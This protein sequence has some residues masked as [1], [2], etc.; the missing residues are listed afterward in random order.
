MA[1]RAA[2][3]RSE[4]LLREE[5]LLAQ[6]AA[7]TVLEEGLYSPL[8]LIDFYRTAP[9]LQ[10]RGRFDA[11]PATAGALLQSL[12]SNERLRAALELDEETLAELGEKVPEAIPAIRA[13]VASGRLE[14]VYGSRGLLS[15]PDAES[16]L[17]LLGHALPLLRQTL[18][19]DI[20]SCLSPAGDLFPQS[21][22]VL[23]GF[24]FR[25]LIAFTTDTLPS[26]RPS[27]TRL[28]GPDGSEMAAAFA[29]AGTS[30]RSET[31]PLFWRNERLEDSRLATEESS[32]AL[33][34]RLNDLASWEGPAAAR[35]AVAARDDIRF[36]TP[37][38][39]FAAATSDTPH[40]TPG[41]VQEGSVSEIYCRDG[42]RGVQA[43]KTL[44]LAECLDALAFAMG[45]ESDERELEHAW[46]DLLHWQ[47]S[48]DRDSV[49]NALESGR[50]SAEAAAKFLASHVD[51]SRI[52]GRGL[53]VFNPSSWTRREY[54]EVT[55]GGEGY[56]IIQGSRELASQ[57][58]ERR[59]GYVTLGF[60]VQVPPLGYRLL[61]V[62]SSTPY[63]VPA[64]VRTA[65][66]TRF[67]ANQFYSAEVG[68]RGGVSVEAA[69]NVLVDAAG[70][71]SAWKD[72]RFHDSREGVQLIEPDRWGPV[73]ERYVAEGRLKGARFRQWITFYRAL[74][75][76]DLRTEIDFGQGMTFGALNNDGVDTEDRRVVSQQ[77]RSASDKRLFAASPFY[78][79]DATGNRA[80]AFGLAGLDD[81]WQRG[82]AIL[83]RDRCSY[84]FDPGQG[85]L[86]AALARVSP[87]TR[88]SGTRVWECALLPSESRLQALR[89]AVEY[90][91]PCLGVF[92]TPHAGNLPPEGSFLSVEP[93]QALLSAAFVRG[94]RV[95]VRLWNASANSAEATVA[96]GG[97]LSLRQ[98]SLSLVDEASVNG[99]VPLRP[100]GVQTLRLA[101]ADER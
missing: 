2:T 34:C 84:H 26:L 24:G 3:R 49:A 6:V 42:R 64:E 74:P 23:A 92:I 73:L 81:E 63:D 55:L 32:P 13:A 41:V 17:R 65:P 88:I 4:R 79:G 59:D 19:V 58:V 72:G 7:G 70:C 11:W 52:E 21:A 33:L 37:Q 96:S 67:F 28:H 71:V 54:M 35:A 66:A 87:E 40:P 86:H 99:S 10:E 61:E 25:R 46:H 38:E 30:V 36:A 14:L 39:Y 94:G 47:T 56:R 62:R 53:V 90:Q 80:I 76:I 16:I 9:P 93:D 97:P 75:R 29:A 57:V 77:F 68:E 12:E 43:E 1:C 31:D 95:Y 60:V 18:G 82:I 15:L 48:L 78:V 85:V 20:E 22:Q 98:C 27:V 69:G 100:W 5:M 51:S 50:A 101:G 8:Y 89:A 45:R 91:L 44:L 83:N